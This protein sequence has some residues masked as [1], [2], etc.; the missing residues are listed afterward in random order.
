MSPRRR[1]V[2]SVRWS[3]RLG[4]V[5]ASFAYFVLL[6]TAA[7][8][9]LAAANAERPP[10]PEPVALSLDQAIERAQI[11]APEVVAAR[12]AVHEAEAHRVGAGVVLPAR[13]RLSIDARPALEGRPLSQVGY[14]AML[15]LLF[16]VGGAPASRVRE[17]NRGVEWAAANLDVE[18]L[19]AR[20]A[21]W[22]TY[23]RLALA[24]RRIEQLQNV[25]AIAKRLLLA[26]EQRANAGAAG[27]IEQSLAKSE[28]SQIEALVRGAK[29]QEE[30]TRMEMR[31]LLDLPAEAPFALTTPVEDPA[32]APPPRALLAR[33]VET[34]PELKAIQKQVALLE[35]T[36]ERLAREVFPRVGTYLGVDAAPLSPMYAIAG[37]SIELPIA[38]RNQGA[39]A[40]T[41]AEIG[42]ALEQLGLE[43]RRVIR[44][45][46]GASAAY[47]L[48]LS[49]LRE[50]S[51]TALPAAER[52]LEL[53]EAGWRSGRFDLFRVTSAERDVA[54]LRGM[55]LDAVEAAW[56]ERIALDRA[57]GGLL[58]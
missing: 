37:I 58:P 1:I 50:L 20:E 39:R 31:E 36:D 29:R 11:R 40:V 12:H 9:G 4:P 43:E 33:A 19:R 27:D 17:A 52:T 22:I 56:T 25:A 28:L 35:A 57:V 34:R 53:V 6:S 16:E 55:R 47:E 13:P 49:E 21:A 32:P 8:S 30:A 5:F 26:S 18:R 23:V 41:Q 42:G 54:R 14:G 7:S 10:G 51:N 2:R 3:I 48:R 24:G 45:V 46:L 38:Q 15:D 44:E